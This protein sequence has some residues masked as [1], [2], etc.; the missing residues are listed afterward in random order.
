MSSDVQ[1]RGTDTLETLLERAFSLDEPLT[2]IESDGGADTNSNG[3]TEPTQKRRKIMSEGAQWEG[4]QPE[5]A[6]LGDIRSDSIR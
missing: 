6:G 2:D 3:E 1:D 4:G 5:G